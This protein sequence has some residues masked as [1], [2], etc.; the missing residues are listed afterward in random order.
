MAKKDTKQV[1]KE[2]LDVDFDNT[3]KAMDFDDDG[4]EEGKSKEREMVAQGPKVIDIKD[5]ILFKKAQR[6]G[7]N[8]RK[9]F[10]N[11]KF[12]DVMSKREFNKLKEK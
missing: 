8:M 4:Y 2:I 11:K 1:T 3:S 12:S 6:E 5:K 10:G 9:L 7:T